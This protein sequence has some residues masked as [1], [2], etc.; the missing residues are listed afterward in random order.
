VIG[1]YVYR[2]AALPELAGHFLYSDY[3]GGWLRS[4]QLTATGP[5]E[6]RLWTGVS[7]P[8]AVSFGRDGAG[9]L[10]LL[11]ESGVFRIVRHE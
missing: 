11:G 9:E 4:F 2:G 3:C 1:G 5:A 8:G 6:H 10:Y 7:L